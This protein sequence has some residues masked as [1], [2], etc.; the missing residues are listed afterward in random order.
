MKEVA[1][2]VAFFTG[3]FP[4]DPGLAKHWVDRGEGT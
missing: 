3:A 2:K 4:V 1:A